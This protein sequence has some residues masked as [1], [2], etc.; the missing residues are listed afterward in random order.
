MVP[1][2]LDWINHNQIIVTEYSGADLR[3]QTQADRERLE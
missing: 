2:V 3:W 1:I